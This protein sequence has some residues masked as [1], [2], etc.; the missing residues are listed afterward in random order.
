M[1]ALGLKKI[2]GY[3]WVKMLHVSSGPEA[4]KKASEMRGEGQK[5]RV[6]KTP[7]GY[8]LYSRILGCLK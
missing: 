1:T 3:Y 7:Y 6:I 4:D 5:V 2:K 8:D